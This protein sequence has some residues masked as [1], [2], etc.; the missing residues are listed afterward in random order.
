M[1]EGWGL[2][3]G[4]GV[5]IILAGHMTL[6]TPGALRWGQQLRAASMDCSSRTAP[7][8]GAAHV[9]RLFDVSCHG[10]MGFCET[11]WH[12]DGHLQ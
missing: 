5:E 10:L 4:Y 1:E 11:V 3:V 12:Q 8:H 6:I 7:L 9:A 2:A